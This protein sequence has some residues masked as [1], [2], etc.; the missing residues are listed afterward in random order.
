MVKSVRLDNIFDCERV[1]CF[2]KLNWKRYF[3]IISKGSLLQVTISYIKVAYKARY[4]L[5][6][7]G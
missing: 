7:L 6:F 3:F 5:S 2:C 4:F 1:S